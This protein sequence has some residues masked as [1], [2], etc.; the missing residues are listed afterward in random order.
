MRQVMN[1]Q[2]GSPMKSCPYCA[3]DIRDEAI[4]CKHCGS[5][6]QTIHGIGKRLHRS[7]HDRQIAGICGGLANYFNVDPVL[8]RVAWVVLAFLSAGLAIVLYLILIVVIPNEDDVRRASIPT[9]TGG[10]R[11]FVGNAVSET[12]QQ[13]GLRH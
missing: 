3:E 12:E 7:Q 5:H 8:M 10:N 6:L 4:R 1:S 9:Q 11:T 2:G 13:E